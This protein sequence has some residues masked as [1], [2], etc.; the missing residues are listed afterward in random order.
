M[1]GQK[2]TALDLE[3]EQVVKE[4][5]CSGCKGAEFQKVC[6]TCGLEEDCDEFKQL[7]AEQKLELAK[8]G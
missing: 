8:H 1:S 2:I 7:V 6:K 5:L 3:A 4:L